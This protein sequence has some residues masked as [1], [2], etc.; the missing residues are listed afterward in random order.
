VGRKRDANEWQDMLKVWEQS[1][2]S[3]TEFCREHD[4]SVSTFDY[5]RKKQRDNVDESSRLVKIPRTATAV[6]E[7]ANI[8]IIIDS[9][10]S[11]DLRDGFTAENLSTVLQAISLCS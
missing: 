4:V 7:T 9:R 1:G 5:W 10:L 8:R 3:R 2:S 6:L 11:V